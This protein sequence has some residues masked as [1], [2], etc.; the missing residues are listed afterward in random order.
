MYPSTTAFVTLSLSCRLPLYIDPLPPSNDFDR[1]TD[2]FALSE[3]YSST[4]LEP[5]SYLTTPQADQSLASALSGNTKDNPDST[6]ADEGCSS[7]TVPQDEDRTSHGSRSSTAFATPL[8]G[9]TPTSSDKEDG[10]EATSRESTLNRSSKG[11][12]RYSREISPEEHNL[13]VQGLHEMEKESSSSPAAKIRTPSFD[14][15]Q[16]PSGSDHNM[17]KSDDMSCTS[18][19]TGSQS[20]LVNDNGSKTTP[21]QSLLHPPPLGSVAIGFHSKTSTASPKVTKHEAKFNGKKHGHVPEMSLSN[22]SING[23]GKRFSKS[24]SWEL[25]PGVGVVDSASISGGDPSGPVLSS[26]STPT[27]VPHQDGGRTDVYLKGIYHGDVEEEKHS[28]GSGSLPDYYSSSPS[29]HPADPPPPYDSSHTVFDARVL[30]S[31][32]ATTSGA[33]RRDVGG[34]R[35]Y[36]SSDRNGTSDAPPERRQL[37]VG[38]PTTSTSTGIRSNGAVPGMEGDSAQLKPKSSLPKR[39]SLIDR[40]CSSPEQYYSPMNRKLYVYAMC[41]KLMSGESAKAGIPE[42]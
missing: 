41:R 21:Q 5:T 13:I 24:E 7:L 34:S 4:D 17:E 16:L 29:S 42:W 19:L 25:W 3:N 33:T 6:N 11:R 9:M 31:W 8:T 32:Q 30:P 36:H 10:S 38:L 23:D 40:Q 15:L 22:V 39:L 18:T 28:A 14:R 26:A 12:Y 27:A 1:P 35:P 20:S 2:S 37:P